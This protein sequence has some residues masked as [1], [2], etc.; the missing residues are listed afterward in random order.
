MVQTRSAGVE[1]ML[2]VRVQ[3]GAS[4]N[5]V[6]GW[7]G[8]TLKLRVTSAPV[9][10]AANSRCLALLSKLLKIPQSHLTLVKGARSRNKVVRIL[11]LS[12]EQVCA[13]L[14]PPSS[15]RDA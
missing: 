7:I 9:E 12:R 10:G 14:V 2:A 11:G 1:T 4:Q 3:P 8:D 15:Q 6:S 13:R 5:A